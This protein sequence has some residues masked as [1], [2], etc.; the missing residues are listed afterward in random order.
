[1]RTHG[2]SMIEGTAPTFGLIIC[3]SHLKFCVH[4]NPTGNIAI[5]IKTKL[6]RTLALTTMVQ[7]LRKRVDIF[8]FSYQ[9]L[10]AN[11]SLFIGSSCLPKMEFILLRFGYVI[12]N[13][14]AHLPK[15]NTTTKYVIHWKREN[16]RETNFVTWHRM[17]CKAND[18]A[19][20]LYF[21]YL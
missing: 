20:R 7:H 1:M 4:S 21:L 9:D 15:Q 11:H 16:A 17:M 12:A 13:E 19:D 14:C 5:I 6:N 8:L 2:N 18:I 3:L 10:D